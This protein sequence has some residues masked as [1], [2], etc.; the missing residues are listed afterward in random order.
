LYVQ[1][2]YSTTCHSYNRRLFRGFAPAPKQ[3]KSPGIDIFPS[4][5]TIAKIGS[6]KGHAE[7]EKQTLAKEEKRRRKAERKELKRERRRL[8]PGQVYARA[9][10]DNRRHQNRSHSP[11]GRQSH[12]YEPRRHW[13]GSSPTRMPL[14]RSGEEQLRH[15]SIVHTAAVR[16]KETER[17]R[18]RQDINHSLA[19]DE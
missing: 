19:R 11:R 7:D 16:D 15:R 4:S 3:I 12:D 8:E 14:T 9:N 18:R 6:A 13:N 17:N 10:R 2:A 5:S 1:F